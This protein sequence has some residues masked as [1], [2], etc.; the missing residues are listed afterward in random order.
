MSSDFF[1]TYLPDRSED[2]SLPALL[3][4]MRR[5]GAVI[6]FVT[7][8]NPIR[9]I[10]EYLGEPTTLA[11]WFGVERRLPAHVDQT[12][13]VVGVCSGARLGVFA[14][15]EVLLPVRGATGRDDRG[16]RR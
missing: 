13:T 2:A 1:V 5:A 16:W 10:L 4:A 6:A 7:E 8:V 9:R 15:I 11:G 14:W 3:H 12:D